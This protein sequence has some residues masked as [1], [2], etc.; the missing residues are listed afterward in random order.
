MWQRRRDETGIA[1]M[2]SGISDEEKREPALSEPLSTYL[3]GARRDWR[4]LISSDK[5]ISKQGPPHV[6]NRNIS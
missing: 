3:P 6:L 4:E 5:A 1:V 2:Q